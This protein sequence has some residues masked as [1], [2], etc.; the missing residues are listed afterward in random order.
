VLT[1]KAP[2]DHHLASAH[3]PAPLTAWLVR[4]ADARRT[5]VV[6]GL[7][8]AILLP[9]IAISS[10]VP[11]VRVEQLLLP[12]ALLVFWA[13]HR[14]G[15]L[16][17]VGPLDW[18]FAALELS[19]LA[20]VV[21]AP[22]IL[23]TRMSP[24]DF[25]ELL[26]PVL[27]YA[28]YRLALSAFSA[29][30][31]QGAGDSGAMGGQGTREAARAAAIAAPAPACPRPVVLSPEARLDGPDG[32][33]I[34][35]TSEPRLPAPVSATAHCPLPTALIAAGGV[36]AL[37]GVF[38]YFDWLRVNEWLTPLYA[39][40]QHLTVVRSA[41]RVVGTIGNPNYFGIFC[42][43]VIVAALAG[44]WLGFDEE[45]A[46]F[47]SAPTWSSSPG[48]AS[49]RS[50]VPRRAAEAALAPSDGTRARRKRSPFSALVPVRLTPHASRFT[51]VACC[52]AA[53]A[54]SLGLVFS[55][56][57]TALLALIA[58]VAGIVLLALV[59]RLAL[60]RLALGVG[61]LAALVAGSVAVAEAFPHG[62]VDYLGRL[63]EGLSLQQDASF[64]L[65]LARWRSFLDAWLPHHAAASSDIHQALTSVHATGVSPAS[66]EIRARDLQRK[67]GLLR[68]AR[69]IDAYHQ[70]TNHW[71]APNALA[72]TLVPA[73]L[74]SLPLD[75]STGQPY[76]DIATVTGY[77]LLARLEDPADPDYP[78][79]GIGSSPNYLLNG[80]LEQGS[81]TPDTWDA[82]P[83]TSYS[84]ERSDVLYGRQAMRYRGDP[85]HPDRRAGVFQQRYFGRPG[86]NL[87][88][89]TVW[90]KLPKPAPGQLELYA[91]VIYTDGDR[92]DPLTRIPVDMSRTGVWQK[93]SLGIHPPA[94]KDI[95]FMG[96]YV[97][98]EGFSGEA[99]IDG[100]QLVDG[101]V[102]LSFARTREAPASDTLG[103]NPEARLRRSPVIGVG[104]AKA[105]QGGSV[106]D[107]YLLYAARYGVIGIVLYLALYLG[108][109]A[110][111]L[112]AFWRL[113]GAARL[114]PVLV[115]ATLTAFLVFNLT[116]GSFYE[117]QLMAIFWL[118]AGAALAA[119]QGGEGAATIA[120]R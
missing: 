89:A 93:V 96:I 36:S 84:L 45:G 102:P 51:S 73:Y 10:R 90:V 79:Y 64:G 58:A 35:P 115:A 31:G 107:E 97:I 112:R 7:L 114:L 77:S 113:R 109:L 40:E 37:V 54:A 120:S 86:G 111:A 83:G 52:V 24:R 29:G 22:L 9:E 119:W 108:T 85:A 2:S 104:P 57:R 30:S 91:N 76:A 118:L 80:D 4:I 88:T 32:V 53:A 99:L 46:G 25:Y 1:Q 3:P 56:S 71:P 17:R 27:Y 5:A 116:A 43:I 82:I 55:G 33:A 68:L 48:T 75:P 78:I 19:T 60:L 15:L 41:G 8:A 74:P 103:F 18:L 23:H 69:A 106:D 92:A 13:D 11:S 42:V 49:S 105:A 62:Q 94:D 63:T 20:S 50:T 44:V 61:V 6:L 66:P 59:R 28:Y 39:P 98:S 101:P 100:F 12:Y 34:G 21:G 117:L 72:V 14:R 110:L 87:F 16:L 95:S 65:R 67:A 38:Q 47:K 81:G 70:Q 26:K